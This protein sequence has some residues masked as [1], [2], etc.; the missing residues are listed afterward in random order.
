[1]KL[2]I[3]ISVQSLIRTLRL[4]REQVTDGAGKNR[5]ESG[6]QK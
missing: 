6:A 5:K 4:L 1:M 3:R 2:A